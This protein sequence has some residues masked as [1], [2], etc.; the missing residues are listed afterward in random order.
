M[1]QNQNGNTEIIND[2]GVFR[3]RTTVVQEEQLT[4]EKIYRVLIELENRKT[5]LQNE[6]A[7]N[8]GDIARYE[9]LLTQLKSTT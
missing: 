7:R 8:S 6:L 2:N 4:A 1:S 5:N 3:V 9:D